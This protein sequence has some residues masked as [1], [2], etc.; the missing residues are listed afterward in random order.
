MV[1]GLV[2]FR[3][4]GSGDSATMYA[5]TRGGIDM[6]GLEFFSVLLRAWVDLLSALA[7][8]LAAVLIALIYK[9]EIHRLLRGL[10]SLKL[11]PLDAQ[12]QEQLEQAQSVAQEIPI[13]DEPH[14]QAGE[15][16]P[17]GSIFIPDDIA[18][19][20][21]PTGTIMETWKAL[22]LLMVRA[23]E[24]HELL[25]DQWTSNKYSPRAT[26]PER[27]LL[28]RGLITKSAADLIG[29]LRRLRNQV[30]HSTEIALTRD[31]VNEYVEL[32]EVAKQIL[33]GLLLD[34]PQGPQ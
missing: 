6:T 3:A 29:H 14:R 22:E 32:A 31:Q 17:E 28:T 2:M 20:A 21:H 11:G 12:F 30:A 25:S 23:V 7:W 5:L 18:V 15:G 27:L 10:R 24:K 8:P 4:L 19:N 1:I 16:S 34:R 9:R 13:A 33:S 26:R